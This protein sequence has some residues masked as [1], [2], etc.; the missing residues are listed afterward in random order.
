MNFLWV[1][2]NVYIL[3]S[4]CLGILFVLF[5]VLFILARCSLRRARDLHRIR[6][7]ELTGEITAQAAL[8]AERDET[9]AAQADT[10]AAQ[11]ETLAAQADTIAAQTEALAAQEELLHAQA[12]TADALI[13]AVIAERASLAEQV[14]LTEEARAECQ[15]LD[16][17]LHCIGETLCAQKGRVG[18]L[19]WSPDAPNDPPLVLCDS[20]MMAALTR[21]GSIPVTRYLRG[22][23]ASG[24]LRLGDRVFSLTSAE[25]DRTG[26]CIV[27]DITADALRIPA[28]ERTVERL[29]D[30]IETLDICTTAMDYSAWLRG[31]KSARDGA[32]TIL[33]VRPASDDR[34]GTGR[35]SIP[36]TYL[37][38]CAELLMH[39][40]PGSPVARCYESDFCCRIDSTDLEAIRETAKAL[41]GAL[42]S[43]YA[44]YFP[45]AEDMQGSLLE[46]CPYPGGQMEH[47]MFS[48]NVRAFEDRREGRTGI[49]SFTPDDVKKILSRWEEL[50][51]LRTRGK[52]KFTYRPIVQCADGRT[53]GHEM[54]PDLSPLGCSDPEELLHDAERF[55]MTRELA[56][57]LCTESLRVH[58][59]AIYDGRL[60]YT[61]R[62]WVRSL[63]GVCMASR[64][65]QAFHEAYYDSL[66]NLILELPENADDKRCIRTKRLRTDSWGAASAVTLGADVEEDLR[67]VLVANPAFVRIPVSLLT[68][69]TYRLLLS[70]LT[71]RRMR[72]GMKLLVDG[73]S[74]VNDLKT[75]MAAGADYLMGDYVGRSDTD[76]GRV[77]DLC[78]NRIA[79]I[80][81]GK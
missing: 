32:S 56:A 66:R 43:L 63:P 76:P 61:S 73:I 48:M 50:E 72:S 78:M 64:D 75:A 38:A 4:V 19:L 16:R 65:E 25:V 22:R 36:E 6:E 51:R 9:V 8:I 60:L 41:P 71:A 67:R 26:V 47:F 79:K 10:I 24:S 2:P 46:L 58:Q 62:L 45:T 23:D 49:C 55:G 27:T 52:L 81:F 68:D 54:I 69:S 14:G 44:A 1:N 33:L 7:A 31:C 15:R 5:T 77:T 35:S 21:D 12:Q 74:T 40:F 29:Q 80:R 13:R 37:K 70:E 28:L 11:A 42:D 3:P 17:L 34:A 59:A 18:L 39:T 30:K 53:Y 20:T 57:F